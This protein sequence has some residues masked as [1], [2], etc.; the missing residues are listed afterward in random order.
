MIDW[1]KVDWADVAVHVIVAVVAV[2]AVAVSP[3]FGALLVTVIFWWRE[4]SQRTEYTRHVMHFWN[5][6]EWGWG[7][8]CEL[9]APA[10]A[11]LAVAA[12]LEV[13]G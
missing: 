9:Y 1:A 10:L 6:L 4:A 7:A 11:A 5:P 3:F 8:Q 2:I 12:L 13:F